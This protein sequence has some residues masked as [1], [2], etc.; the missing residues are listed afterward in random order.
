MF[1]FVT[2][3]NVPAAAEETFVRGLGRGGPWLEQVRRVT[4]ALVGAD[5]L[6][7]QS[8]PVFLC[9]DIWTAPEG[10]AQACG[11]Q[12]VRQLLDARKQMAASSFEIGGFIF[13]KLTETAGVSNARW[14]Q[15]W[16]GRPAGWLSTEQLEDELFDAAV[17]A[18]RENASATLA[19][20]ARIDAY[21]AKDGRSM[22][23][24]QH[25]ESLLE[26]LRLLR[27]HL[28]ELLAEPSSLS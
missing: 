26:L 15:T 18:T 1:Y 12:A 21:F 19:A 10:Y 25:R 7:H 9:H 16:P 11:S 23:E 28:A 6:R 13:P 5:L 14:P 20:L 22:S 3:F 8:W 2:L 24:K 27:P 17:Q 4:P